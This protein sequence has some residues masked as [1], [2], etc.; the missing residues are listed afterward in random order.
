LPSVWVPSAAVRD[1]REVVRRRLG[2]REKV[3]RVKNEVSGLLRRY[4]LKKPEGLKTPWSK[5]Y[6]LWLRSV[7]AELDW[8]ASH[9][10]LSLLR[11]Y[12]FLAG[13][14]RRVEEEMVALSEAERYA[15]PV[16]AL[17]ELCGVGLL[18]AMVFLTE[19]GELSRFRNRRA[20]GSYLGLT[21]RSWE[22][23]EA[24]DRKGHISK[25]GP[26]RIR[27]VLSQASWTRVRHDPESGAW[28]KR[29]TPGGKNKKKVITAQMRRLG[30][31][32]WHTALEA[33]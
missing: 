20:L 23:G 24:S 2:L 3:T 5:K 7:A 9:H 12:E 29:R 16:A 4:R 27:M 18:T 30:I 13:E 1:D 17:V 25:L 14:C 32:M 8:G 22:S 31:L 26:P 21:P 11:E 28:F 15:K 10:L 6:V 33:A 19:L